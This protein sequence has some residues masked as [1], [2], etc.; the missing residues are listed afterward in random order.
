MN[1]LKIVWV[2]PHL[3]LKGLSGLF[4]GLFLC[5]SANTHRL[6][7]NALKCF[8]TSLHFT[9]RSQIHGW[10]VMNRFSIWTVRQRTRDFFPLF[11]FSSSFIYWFTKDKRTQVCSRVQHVKNEY[12][13]KISYFLTVAFFSLELLRPIIMCINCMICVDM[14]II[15]GSY[16]YVCDNGMWQPWDKA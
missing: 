4:G 2:L 3:C 6:T 11:F 9:S 14:L 12:I 7:V 13:N 10:I 5:P 8:P 16:S 1:V 15:T